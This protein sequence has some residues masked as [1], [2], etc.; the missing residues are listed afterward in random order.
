[1]RRQRHDNGNPQLVAQMARAF[2][3]P[4]AKAA[5]A[6]NAAQAG[7]FER[8]IY[9]TQ[10]RHVPPRGLAACAQ[11]MYI[12]RRLVCKGC[13]PGPGVW[14]LALKS[15]NTTHTFVI[16]LSTGLTAGAHIGRGDS[17]PQVTQ[18]RCY[19]A[20]ISYWRRIKTEPDARTMGVLYWQAR[21]LR[22]L[23]S[24]AA[25]PLS[26]LDFPP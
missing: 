4:D 19:Q 23:C 1:M 13:R 20:A 7:T 17:A 26:S 2:K 11:A 3:V 8:F 6:S 10:A 25:Q 21:P 15:M 5:T 12:S 16:S 9:L 24:D 22:R 18:A 14:D